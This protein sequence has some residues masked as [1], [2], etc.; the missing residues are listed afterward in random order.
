MST[1]QNDDWRPCVSY[2]CFGRSASL[3]INEDAIPFPEE[4]L[5]ERAFPEADENEEVV[6]K[7]CWKLGGCL[8][9]LPYATAKDVFDELQRAYSSSEFRGAACFLEGFN[10]LK[11]ETGLAIYDA[12]YGS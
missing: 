8:T 5:N 2:N 4:L 9:F 11:K 7:G 1:N 3:L 6:L 10:F 12:F